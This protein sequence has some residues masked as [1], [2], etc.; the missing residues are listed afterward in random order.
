MFNA[1]DSLACHSERSEE[2]PSPG[3]KIL[4]CAQN[5]RREGYSM[6][7]ILL[8]QKAGAYFDGVVPGLYI[9]LKRLPICASVRVYIVSSFKG[10]NESHRTN[11]M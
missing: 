1:S 2:S 10:L 11:D 7:H 9:A 4:R 3:T 6:G 5:D 8:L